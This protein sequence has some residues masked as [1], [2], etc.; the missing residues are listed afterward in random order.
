MR[1]GTGV[2]FGGIFVSVCGVWT[3][4]RK[5]EYGVMGLIVGRLQIENPVH[6]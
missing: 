2:L 3:N 6:D 1:L 4:D 5:V